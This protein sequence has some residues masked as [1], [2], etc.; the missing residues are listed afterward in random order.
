MSQLS[1]KKSKS[2]LAAMRQIVTRAANSA[3][4]AGR[5]R[6]F[7]KNGKQ[8]LSNLTKDV[9]FLKRIINSELKHI[10]TVTSANFNPSTGAVVAL[11]SVAEGS[12]S[13]QR[14][15]R[16]IKIQRIDLNMQIMYSTGT[17]ATT[18]FLDNRFTW[19]LVQYLATPSTSGSAAFAI[20]DFLDVDNNS[21]YSCMSMAD[22]DTAKD[23]RVLASG[24]CDVHFGVVP[25]TSA[26]ARAY[27]NSSTACGFH[28]AFNSTTA[29]S[30]VDNN[31]CVVITARNATNTGGALQYTLNARMWFS[32]N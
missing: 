11:T 2:G 17:A 32:D 8:N 15:G 25:A 22:P 3:V 28:Q 1:T 9:M 29:A 4:D 31:V 19:F 16:S 21:T 13:T 23:F 14:T 18:Q 6:Y 5:Q 24:L 12:D 20:A 27:V 26:E 30:I 7:S 10:E